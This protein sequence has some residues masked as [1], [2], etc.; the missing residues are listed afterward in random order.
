MIDDVVLSM[1]SSRNL[2]FAILG[3]ILG[4]SSGYVFAFYRAQ[5]SQTP[6]PLTET[7]AAA[8]MP[9]G[10]PDVNND[11]MLAA[12]KKAV[13]NDPTQP[14]VVKRY[15]M[16]LFDAGHF[17]E[18]VQW[19]GKAVELEPRSVDTR[20][21]Y[22]AVLWRVGN[23]ASAAV[24][25]EE[26]LKLDPRNIPSLHGLTLLALESGNATRA[27]ELIRK[28]EGIEPTYDQLPDLRTRLQAIRG[29]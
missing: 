3:I 11:Q 29:K 14:E 13:E 15:A 26:T 9:A 24:Q 12:M 1:F 16:A 20:S 19:F 10:H 21:M 4:E 17:E 8:D 5:S 22:A 18:A 27:N 7:Q 6:P 28:I 2:H 23:K 25:L